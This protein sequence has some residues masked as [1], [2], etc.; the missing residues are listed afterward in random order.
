MKALK[1]F[2]F[3]HLNYAIKNKSGEYQGIFSSNNFCLLR[4]FFFFNFP[5]FTTYGPTV[6]VVRLIKCFQSS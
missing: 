2:L 3:F 5:T 6:D 4:I 1:Y